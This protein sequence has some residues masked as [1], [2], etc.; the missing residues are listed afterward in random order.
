MNKFLMYALFPLL[1][2]AAALKVTYDYQHS[3]QRIVAYI[4]TVRATQW[5]SWRFSR[6]LYRLDL[7]LEQQQF[8]ADDEVELE[9]RLAFLLVSYDYFSTNAKVLPQL[10]HQITG[11]LQRQMQQIEQ[12]ELTA[13]PQ[14]STLRQLDRLL[15]QVQQRYEQVIFSNVRSAELSNFV[16][17]IE[18]DKQQLLMII[19]SAFVFGVI[20]LPIWM[21]TVF[22][23]RRA[24]YL[25]SIDPL[26]QLPNRAQCT[27][28]LDNVLKRSQPVACVFFDL[29]GFKAINDNHGHHV[30]DALLQAIGNRCRRQIKPR[31]RF[32]R[33]GGDEFVLVLVNFRQANDVLAVVQRLLEQIEQPVVV[34]EQS[35]QVGAA[36]GVAYRSL[37]LTSSEELLAAADSAM[38]CAKKQK[39]LHRSAVEVFVSS[40]IPKTGT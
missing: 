21:A 6:D 34:D 7:M 19:Y 16:A 20:A 30:G 29:N 25:S 14:S 24:N 11:Q 33:I 3:Q 37:Q 28:H 31:D 36:V 5:A 22:R 1:M 18:R 13:S 32:C 2:L 8:S 4:E 10:Q 40:P 35:V 39:A 23:F 15:H 27:Q 38:Y 12:L 17:G 9:N 26:T